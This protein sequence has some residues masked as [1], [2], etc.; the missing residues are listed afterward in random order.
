MWPSIIDY[1]RCGLKVTVG[2]VCKRDTGIMAEVSVVKNVG[3]TMEV[4]VACGL[5]VAS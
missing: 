4:S 5:G 2:L 3:V 1:H